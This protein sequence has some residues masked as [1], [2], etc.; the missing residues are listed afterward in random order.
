MTA[1]VDTRVYLLA[2]LS[3]MMTQKPTGTQNET[4]YYNTPVY[5]KLEIQLQRLLS[6]SSRADLIRMRTRINENDKQS[7]KYLDDYLLS[8]KKTKGA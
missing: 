5:R 1:L 4:P 3:K 2:K 6:H 8:H 7:L